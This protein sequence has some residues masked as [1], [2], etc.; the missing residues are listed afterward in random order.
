MMKGMARLGIRL[1]IFAGLACASLALVYAFTKDSIDHQNEIQLQASLKEIFPQA[2]SFEPIQDL[3]SSDPNIKFDAAYEVKSDMAP[4]GI[5]V[6]VTGPSYGGA[7]TLLVGVD[8][9]RTITGV[10]IMV[11]SDTP[12]LGMNATNPTYYVDKTKKITFLGQFDGKALSDPFQVK[13][14]V[15]AITAATISSRSLTNIIK[16]AGNAAIAYMDQKAI[17][18][19]TNGSAQPQNSTA[20]NSAQ[21]QAGGK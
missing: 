3:T 4:L 12:G 17:T 15:V 5:A 2:V 20:G 10:R 11:L 13:N 8:L 21:P 14:D 16:T 9:L 7:A 1:A 6:K 18:A 19:P